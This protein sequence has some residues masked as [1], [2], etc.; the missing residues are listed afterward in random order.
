[1]PLKPATG[2]LECGVTG[3]GVMIHRKRKTATRRGKGPKRP[4]TYAEGVDEP[5]GVLDAESVDI[6]QGIPAADRSSV[7]AVPPEEATPPVFEE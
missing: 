5:R 6:E 7:E 3:R 4:F 2:A 1:M